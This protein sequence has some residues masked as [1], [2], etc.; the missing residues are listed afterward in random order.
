M[1]KQ[2]HYYGDLVRKL[3]LG[4]AI[5]MVI[6]LPFLN[7]LLPFS[8]FTSLIV[9]IA[10]SF[11]AGITTPLER[12]APLLNEITSVISVLVFEYY[13]VL[14]YNEYGISLIFIVNQVLALNFLT[15]LYYS[16]KNLRG[17]ITAPWRKEKNT[18]QD[19]DIG[20]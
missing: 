4:G 13:A 11:V 10:L 3:F 20:L 15:A 1:E 17:L 2:V 6:T 19:V 9:I 16:T 5:V 18:N 8:I 7:T 12:W 14:Y